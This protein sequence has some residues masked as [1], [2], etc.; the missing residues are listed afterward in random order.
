[1][2]VAVRVNKAIQTDFAP[3]AITS[4]ER[5]ERTGAEHE[6][7]WRQTAEKGSATSQQT[8]RQSAA[9]GAWTPHRWRAICRARSGELRARLA[10]DRPQPP[11]ATRVVPLQALIIYLLAKP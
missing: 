11:V 1:M 4:C 5:L 10:V 2:T 6:G 9:R 3:G 7:G 8:P